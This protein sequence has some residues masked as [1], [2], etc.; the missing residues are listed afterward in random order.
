MLVLL[1]ACSEPSDKTHPDTAADDTAGDSSDTDTGDTWDDTG[2]GDSAETGETAESAE[3][4]LDGDGAA[5]AFDC[6]DGDATVYPGAPEVCDGRD[7]D[8]DGLIDDAC[9]SAP[10]GVLPTSA[11][12]ARVDGGCEGGWMSAALGD[13]DGDGQAD[14]IGRDQCDEATDGAGPV[15]GVSAPTYGTYTLAADGLRLI[16]PGAAVTESY[17]VYDPTLSDADGDGRAEVL[18]PRVILY[19]SDYVSSNLLFR[20]PAWGMTTDDATITVSL[21]DQGNHTEDL[22]G[23]VVIGDPGV[24][25]SSAVWMD[26]FDSHAGETWIVPL[27]VEGVY[28]TAEL[29]TLGPEAQNHYNSGLTAVQPLDGGDLNGDGEHE[30]YFAQG[31]QSD[32]YFGPLYP[33]D[34]QRQPDVR[35]AGEYPEADYFERVFHSAV[36]ADLDGDGRDE[37]VMEGLPAYDDLDAYR[38]GLTIARW[39]PKTD[40]VVPDDGPVFY[41]LTETIYD[42]V[43]LDA[44]AD[45]RVDLAVGVP[46]ESPVAESS[47]SVHIEYGPFAGTN[48]LG[49]ADGA[50]IQGQIEDESAGW[51]LA[52]GDVNADGFPD[53]A[54]GTVLLDEPGQP[55]TTWIFTGGP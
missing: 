13:I 18:L 12:A 39:E 1:L 25:V 11:A 40:T 34:G 47:G 38:S 43:V 48:E 10:R 9:G 16:D 28:S 26:A 8:C 32:I 33:A 29:S 4:D 20:T 23:A 46:S 17:F 51:R 49:T 24:L 5:A 41:S 55:G 35:L 2:T 50:W 15:R 19:E 22:R 42:F 54:I 31:R 52:S 45:G 14:L 37:L 3:P 21:V 36:A 27:D 6:D 44:D 7:Q 30:L 53:L